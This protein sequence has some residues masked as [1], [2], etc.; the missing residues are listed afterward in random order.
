MLMGGPYKGRK[1]AVPHPHTGGKESEN[2]R[3]AVPY[4]GV[5]VTHGLAEVGV[6]TASVGVLNLGL[7]AHLWRGDMLHTHVHKACGGRESHYTLT[8]G[9]EW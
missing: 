8:G 2:A 9:R 4:V 3:V 7:G 1:E 5:T 6:H